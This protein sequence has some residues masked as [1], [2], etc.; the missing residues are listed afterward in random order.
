M[1]GLFLNTFIAYDKCSVLNT[2]YLTQP[3][4]MNYLK[5]KNISHFF[6]KFLKSRLNFEK[7][8]KKDDTHSQ[9]VWEITDFQK[10]G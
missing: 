6:S 3:I 4:H 5:N 2:E 8:Q 1:L 9:C 10:Y 7:I